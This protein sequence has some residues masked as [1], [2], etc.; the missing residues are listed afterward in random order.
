M[1]V[2]TLSDHITD[3]AAIAAAQRQAAFER[4]QAQYQRAVQAR[5]QRL[6]NIRIALELSWRNGN[7]LG[8]ITNLFKRL[9]M[10]FSARPLPPPPPAPDREEIVWASGWTGERRVLM[11]FADYL[12]DDWVLMTGYRNAKG[13]IDQLLVG[14]QGIFAI[15]IKFLNGVIHCDGDYW[16]RDKYDRYGNL[17][18][19]GLTIADKRG[20]SPSRQLN[21]AADMLQSFLARRLGV[22]D[23]YR[24]IIFAHDSSKLGELRHATVD[25]VATIYGLNLPNLLSCSRTILNPEDIDRVTRMIS[26]DHAFHNKR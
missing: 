14:P 5:E 16:W 1:R 3:Q 9:A 8:V 11:F 21:E 20:R 22:N 19:T 26:K 23:I 7:I 2:I 18:E 12:S 15:E 17:V 4:V 25:Y 24:A 6:A 13:E 10:S